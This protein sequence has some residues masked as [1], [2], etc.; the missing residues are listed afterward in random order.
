M[1]SVGLVLGAGGAVGAAF[2]AGVLAAL[3]ET[4]FDARRASIIVGTSAGSGV[5]ASLRAGFPPADLA[6]R[7]M[8]RP[9]SPEADALVERTSGPPSMDYRQRPFSR[10]PVPSSPSLLMR[11][12]RRPRAALVGLLPTGT[13][14]NDLIRERIG[15]LYG[16]VSWPD[17]PL[18]V[19][20]VDLDRGDRVVF[21]RDA[22]D[23][24]IG[25][26]VQASSSIPGLVRPVVHHGR[27]YV[28]GG[29]HSP[30]NADLLADEG[31]DLVVVVSPM[32]TTSEG[33][34]AAIA[35]ARPLHAGRL[36]AEVVRLRRA[37]TAVLTFQPTTADIVAMGRNPLDLRRRAPTAESAFESART[38][39]LDPT[40]AERVDMLMATSG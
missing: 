24:P 27:R 26:A 36:A 20:A 40:I 31:L 34:R 5:G 21:G 1:G 33:R 37:G 23:V 4:G 12:V 14:S 22:I 15:E 18:W 39:L 9:L 29:V 17:R 38:R 7:N 2:H 8:G 32:S 35:S 19:C 6:A 11:S 28:D 30:T 10:L 16:D 13:A 3:A 25:V